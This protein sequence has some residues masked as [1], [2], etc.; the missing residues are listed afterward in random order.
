VVDGLRLVESGVIVSLPG[1]VAQRPHADTDG[2]GREAGAPAEAPALKVQLA[3]HEVT[4]TMG[5]IELVL[6]SHRVAAAD[7][8]D[9]QGAAAGGGDGEEPGLLQVPI[10]RGAALLYDTRL[11]HRGGANRS[12][13]RRPVFYV[14][15]L[16]PSGHPPG[17]LPYTIEPA[18]AGCAVLR[19]DGLDTVL[20]DGEVA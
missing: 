15:L 18:E 12:K 7:E 19:P 14:T 3:A 13:R 17:G 11:R 8:G 4:A 2:S 10:P 1:A 16:G 5:P 9:V 20:C 6:G